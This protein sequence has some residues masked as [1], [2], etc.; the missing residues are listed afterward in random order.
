SD[1]PQSS[2]LSEVELLPIPMSIEEGNKP[3]KADDRVRNMCV[4]SRRV[5][6]RRIDGQ[7]CQNPPW[8]GPHLR[9]QRGSQS[10][11]VARSLGKAQ[12]QQGRV[13]PERPSQNAGVQQGTKAS[14][15]IPRTSEPIERRTAG[16]IE[17]S[18]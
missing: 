12:A 3:A 6:H 5:A 7:G 1:Y 4:Q 2:A 13:V 17:P 15:R 8:R 9:L 14:L 16:H 11:P 18:A 10:A